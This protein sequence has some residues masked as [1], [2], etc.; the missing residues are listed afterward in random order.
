M[1]LGENMNFNFQTAV[2][3]TNRDRQIKRIIPVQ[4]VSAKIIIL[5][6]NTLYIFTKTGGPPD[7]S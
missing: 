6:I 4:K 7:F 5:I 1:G 3:N 2:G